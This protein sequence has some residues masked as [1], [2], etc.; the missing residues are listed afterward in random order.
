MQEERR[1]QL[2]HDARRQ[3]RH[4]DRP[5]A[6]S[7]VARSNRPP[8]TSGGDIDTAL[9]DNYNI[10]V[11]PA[12]NG[13][14][15]LYAPLTLVEDE[16]TGN[17][18]A[19]N[20][21]LLYQSAATWKPQQV[22]LSWLVQVLNETYKSPEDAEKALAGMAGDNRVTVLHAYYSDFYLTGLNVREDRGVD[23]A[24]VYEDPAT[25][26]NVNHDDALLQMMNGLDNSFMVN[27]DCDF[28]DNQGACVGNGQGTSPS[29]P[30]SSAGTARATAASPKGSAGASSPTACV[31]KPSSFAHEDEATIHTGTQHAPPSSTAASPAPG[32]PSRLCSL[33]ANR[34]FRASN[35]DVR[36]AGSSIV[37]WTGNSLTLSLR[38]QP[39]IISGGYN[40]A[41]T[42]SSAARI[43]GRGRR[44]RSTSLN[45]RD[46]TPPPRSARRQRPLSPWAIRSHW[47]WSPPTPSRATRPSSRRMA[48]AASAQPSR[49]T[50]RSACKPPIS[51]MS[52]C[53]EVTSP[54]Q[55]TSPLPSPISLSRPCSTAPCSAT[56]S[57][58]TSPRVSCR[59]SRYPRASCPERN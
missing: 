24:I 14:Y 18:V 55:Q 37:T 8:R 19:F 34:A 43:P 47:S 21:Q 12:G 38:D 36:A 25:D 17:K 23:M 4:Q 49:R 16:V 11:R 27:R 9:L 57:G 44:R 59:K 3:R 53:A 7:D 29:P 52:I 54:R 32:P 31:E 46:A 20:A 26:A 1:P 40:L 5:H 33:C 45:W 56:S 22:R 28:V 39:E 35:V 42:S 6:R 58:L 41:P 10:S 48:A 50:D 51:T 15:L 30:S 13:G 2:R